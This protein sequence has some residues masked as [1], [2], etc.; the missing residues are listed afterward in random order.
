[1][2]VSIELGWAILSIVVSALF[3]G[4][5][6]IGI[7]NRYHKSNEVRRAKLKVFQQLMGNRFDIKSNAFI[8][9]LNQTFVVFYDSKEVISALK[10]FHEDAMSAN[11]STAVSNQ[12]LLELF[13][14]MS[15]HLHIKTEPLNDN[16]FMVPFK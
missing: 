12:K 3:S 11:R 16:F 13:K 8:E 10:A 15:K 7:S 5:L 9:A 4:L 1:M 6:G 2:T 14:S